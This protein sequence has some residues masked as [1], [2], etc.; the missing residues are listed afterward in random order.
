VRQTGCAEAP[1][2]RRSPGAM[3]WEKRPSWPQRVAR[4]LDMDRWTHRVAGPT[5]ASRSVE[6]RSYGQPL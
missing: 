3:G 1:M 5:M 2:L 6:H 4:G